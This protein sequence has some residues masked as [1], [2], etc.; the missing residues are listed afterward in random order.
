[1]LFGNIEFRATLFDFGGKCRTLLTW[2]RFVI[3]IRLELSDVL[4]NRAGCCFA[5]SYFTLLV[6]NSASEVIPSR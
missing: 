3:R 1:M 2:E 4:F 5:V 6:Q